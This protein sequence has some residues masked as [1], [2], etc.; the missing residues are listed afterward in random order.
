M[1][2]VHVG[3]MLNVPIF[4]RWS[5]SPTLVAGGANHV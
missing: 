3:A 5:V 1:S 4:E 2:L